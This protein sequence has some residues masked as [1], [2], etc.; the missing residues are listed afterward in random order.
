[1]QPLTLLGQMIRRKF[2]AGPEP[3]DMFRPGMFLSLSAIPFLLSDEAT[4]VASPPIDGAD[5]KTNIG[6]IAYVDCDGLRLT[7]LYVPE[8]EARPGCFQVELDDQGGIAEC[9]FFREIDTVYPATEDEWFQWVNPYWGKPVEL[10]SYDPAYARATEVAQILPMIGHPEFQLTDGTL[11]GRHWSQ[12]DYSI[13]PFLFTETEIGPGGT[14]AAR[15]NRQAMLYSRALD[16]PAPAPAAEYV[17]VSLVEE[18]DAASIRIE[19]G[20]DI[21]PGSIQAA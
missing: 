12:G 16:L 11:Y 17:L 2:G 1:M 10:D 4:H 5:I 19:C 3:R 6:N 21:P 8:I 18:G 7:R 20:I 9:R 15:R 13:E 14:V